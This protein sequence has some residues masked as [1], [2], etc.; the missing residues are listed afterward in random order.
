MS[1]KI[2]LFSRSNSRIDNKL[3]RCLPL[4]SMPPPYPPSLIGKRKPITYSLT[5]LNQHFVEP[6][7][8][9]NFL[10]RPSNSFSLSLST[11]SSFLLPFSPL[12]PPFSSS[13][14]CP[15]IAEYELPAANKTSGVEVQSSVLTSHTSAPRRKF[16]RCTNMRFN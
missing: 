16:I 12:F 5:R 8:S 14:Q 7:F 3:T 11:P 9:S 10:Q 4:F 1:L 6:T 13:T 15:G 2:L